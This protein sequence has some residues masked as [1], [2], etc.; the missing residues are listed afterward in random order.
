MSACSQQLKNEFRL[1]RHSL[2]IIHDEATSQTTL[3]QRNINERVPL[4]SV[5]P[6]HL[7]PKSLTINRVSTVTS[8]EIA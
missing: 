8:G 7:I 5:P 6:N 2:S 4:G 3:R 1:V